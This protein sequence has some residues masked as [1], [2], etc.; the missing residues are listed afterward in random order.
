M[1]LQLPLFLFKP[2]MK[3]YLRTCSRRLVSSDIECHNLFSSSCL[4]TTYYL[5]SLLLTLCYTDPGRGS[6]FCKGERRRECLYKLFHSL[7]E[8]FDM[9]HN[10]A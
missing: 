8:D 10:L 2:V 7:D 5:L 9:E 3:K 4:L 1:N 6:G